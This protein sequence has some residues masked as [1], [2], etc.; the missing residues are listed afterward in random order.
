MESGKE[1]QDR[2]VPRFPRKWLVFYT[3]PKDFTFVC[4]TEILEFDDKLGVFAQRSPES[5]LPAAGNE[6]N[7]R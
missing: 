6:A 3:Y 5:S 7:R 4:P 1:F 2:L